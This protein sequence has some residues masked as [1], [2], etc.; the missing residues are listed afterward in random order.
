MFLLLFVLKPHFVTSQVDEQIML[1]FQLKRSR[2]F[3]ETA[4]AQKH[5]WC[6]CGHA[7]WSLLPSGCSSTMPTRT[8]FVLTVRNSSWNHVAILRSLAMTAVPISPS[9]ND[10]NVSLFTTLL[11]LARTELGLKPQLQFPSP[12]DSTACLYH[13][14]ASCNMPELPLAMIAVLP[15]YVR[16][17]L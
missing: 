10:R 1:W 17:L 6:L 2:R 8:A 4:F 7:V 11:P 12:Y 9:Y 13:C 14:S 3:G 15:R 16:P 5:F